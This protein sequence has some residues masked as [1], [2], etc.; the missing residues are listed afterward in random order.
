[1]RTICSAPIGTVLGLGIATTINGVV[2]AKRS[3]FLPPIWQAVCKPAMCAFAAT[4]AAVWLKNHSL[5]Q[6]GGR[7]MTVVCMAIAVILYVV[8]LIVSKTL[9]KEDL[10]F[11]KKRIDHID[12]EK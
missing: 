8:G 9:K 12:S 2:L 4:V 7:L 1:M 10:R 3:G 11:L 5:P 6:V